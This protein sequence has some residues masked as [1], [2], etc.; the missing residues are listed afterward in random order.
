MI[1]WIAFSVAFSRIKKRIL[2]SLPIQDRSSSN[3][4]ISFGIIRFLFR[5][6]TRKRDNLMDDLLDVHA[7]NQRMSFALLG[8]IL[9]NTWHICSWRFWNMLAWTGSACDNTHLTITTWLCRSLEPFFSQTKF[10]KTRFL[11]VPFV[12][13]GANVHSYRLLVMDFMEIKSLL[14]AY[15]C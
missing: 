14:F 15:S 13:N 11:D 10:E 7:I 4:R 6:T 9:V 3:E 5:E 1:S 2:I 12:S 8:N